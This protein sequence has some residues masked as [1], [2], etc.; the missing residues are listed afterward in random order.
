MGWT[1]CPSSAAFLFSSLRGSARSRDSLAT[2]NKNSTQW[3]DHRNC[4]PNQCWPSIILTRM[5]LPV[6][7]PA[8][9]ERVP[10]PFS[11]PDWLFED[12]CGRRHNS[13]V[14]FGVMWRGDIVYWPGQHSI[15][16]SRRHI[17]LLEISQALHQAQSPPSSARRSRTADLA[18][19]K[20]LSRISKSTFV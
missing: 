19:P 5:S 15:S 1:D 20:R 17:I 2:L 14:A 18:S 12:L 6:C 10:V 13:S 7:W 3:R 8:T 11:H 9:L 16:V 4:G